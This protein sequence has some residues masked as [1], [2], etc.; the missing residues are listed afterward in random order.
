MSMKSLYSVGSVPRVKFVNKVTRE[1]VT[2]DHVNSAEADIKNELFYSK[3]RGIKFLPFMK[4]AEGKFTMKAE[5][6]SDFIL[7]KVLGLGLI[8]AKVG[9]GVTVFKEKN[10][11]TIALG[12]AP[13][14]TALEVPLNNSMSVIMGGVALKLVTGVP[15]AGEYAYNS[16]TKIISVLS[17]TPIGTVITVEGKVLDETKKK[18]LFQGSSIPASFEVYFDV[19]EAIEGGE[20]VQTTMYMGNVSVNKNLKISAEAEKI[21]EFNFDCEILMDENG[22]MAELVN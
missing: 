21:S 13:A 17:T 12:V 8:E 5:A 9:N 15:V 18:M 3:S 6:T 22:N 7:S 20:T 2:F 19:F 10:L 1:S 4:P 16:T 14:L 11:T